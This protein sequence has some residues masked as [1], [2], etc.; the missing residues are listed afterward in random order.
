MRTASKSELAYDFIKER[1]TS[2]RFT[3]GYRLVLATIAADLGIS[4]V[5]VREASAVPGRSATSS[6][7]AP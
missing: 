4:V 7:C 3:P 6:R 1:I 2:G 5:P